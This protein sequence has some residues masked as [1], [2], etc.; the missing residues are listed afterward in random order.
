MKGPPTRT[1]GA[2]LVRLLAALLLGGCAQ[3]TQAGIQPIGRQTVAVGDTLRVPLVVQSGAGTLAFDFRGPDLPGLDRSTSIAGN[4]AGGLFV[5]SP[6]ASHVG[7]HRFTMLLLDG[8]GDELDSEAVTIEVVSSGDS[9][10]VFLRPG[11]GGTYDLERSPSVAFEIEVRD[12]DTLEVDI[13]SRMPL[14]EGASITPLGPKRASFLWVPTPDQVDASERWTI[15]LEAD[16]REHAPTPHDY[17]V[18]LRSGP[19][20]DCPGGEPMVR[21]LSPGD[22]ERVTSRAGFPVEVEV[23]DDMGLRDAP[24]L[25]YS[26]TEP[27]DPADPDVTLFEQLTLSEDGGQWFAR[28]PDPGLEAGAER[29]MFLVASATDN[30][31]P[32]GSQCDHRTDTALRSFIAVGGS[33]GGALGRCERCTASTDCASGVCATAAGGRRC[34]DGCA[35]G[36]SCGAGTCGDR[37]TAEGGVAR[38]CG[39]VAEVCEGGG[40][41]SC[42]EDSFE[43]NDSIGAAA[44]AGTG[45]VMAQICAGNDDYFRITATTGTDVAVV[46]DGFAH[47]DGDLD[48]QLL[49]GA[50]TIL[51]TSAGVMNSESVSHCVA[52]AGDVYARVF[53]YGGAENAYSIRVD[54]T[55]GSCCTDDGGEDDDTRS[56]AR[57]FTGTDFDGTICPGDD[58]HVRFGVAGPTAVRATLVFDTGVGDLDLELYG[59]TGTLIDSSRGSTGIEEIDR[60]VTDPGTYTLR[61]YGYRDAQGDYLG[62][63]VLTAMS[64]CSD[65]NDCPLSEVCDGGA[66]RPRA[67]TS[68]GSCPTGHAC[69]IAGP[70]SPTSEC[71]KSCTVNS[72]CRSSEACKRF[73]GGRYCARRGGGANG[74]ACATFGDCGGQ[75]ACMPYAGGYCARAGCTSGADCETGTFCVDEGA[76]SICALDCWASDSICRSGYDCAARTDLDGFIQFVCVP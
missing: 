37:T 9:A 51:D 17:V 10:P 74:A 70:G 72:N 71:G 49:T 57:S 56:S 29:R 45:A 53:G 12:N 24:L 7:E 65:S 16:D 18:V 19:K 11:A 60:D 66:C 30:D 58:D 44:S 2:W 43:P 5:W 64:G 4:A 21:I 34:L 23:L 59:P 67:C 13:W 40:G 42:T 28:V 1:T 75:R 25:Y 38:A 48:L 63:V 33:G 61:V 54:R 73:P 62:E 6:L 35:G 55:S 52:G 20:D 76:D 50:G 22:G 32:T 46:V 39:S 31:D 26:G 14:P 3:G 47:A 41:G 69:P 36:A 68:S 8:S 27:D 15:P